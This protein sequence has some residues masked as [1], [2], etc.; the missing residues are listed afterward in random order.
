MRDFNGYLSVIGENLCQAKYS[1]ICAVQICPSETPS[2]PETY[3]TLFLTTRLPTDIHSLFA[4]FVQFSS[5]CTVRVFSLLR[6]LN[7]ARFI[8]K[9]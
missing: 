8:R 7:N 5:F 1:L 3:V 4:V 6:M 2:R 9:E